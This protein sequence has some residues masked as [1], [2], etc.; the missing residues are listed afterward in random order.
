MK[1]VKRILAV[2]GV[3]LLVLM[4]LVTLLSAVFDVG[5]SMDLF[6][7]WVVCS[8][9]VPILLWGYLVIY[10]IAKGKDEKELQETLQR[11]E[12]EKG[13]QRKEQHKKR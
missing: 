10:R 1:Q 6:R 4:Y 3:V 13:G 11:M 7:A 9:L 5:S 12:D 8:V 2:M